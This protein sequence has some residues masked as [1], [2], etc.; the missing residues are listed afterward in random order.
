MGSPTLSR[1]EVWRDLEIENKATNTRL[2]LVVEL[3]LVELGL[4]MVYDGGICG[5]GLVMVYGDEL[6]VVYG[7]GSM[8]DKRWW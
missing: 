8:A 1:L 4:M 7:D 6:V 2:G 5:L 3:N